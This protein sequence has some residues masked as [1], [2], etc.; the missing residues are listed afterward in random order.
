M[1]SLSPKR[2]RS[3]S[4]AR[5]VEELEDLMSLVSTLSVARAAGSPEPS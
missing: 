2:R 1:A 3:L 4:P 5:V